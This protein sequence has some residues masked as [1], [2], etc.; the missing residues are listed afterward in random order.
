MRLEHF[1]VVGDHAEYR[2][3]G[4][5]S[6][7][8]M[9]QLV[10]SAI[11]LARERQVRKLLVVTTELTGFEPPNIVDR[12]FFIREWAAAADRS[13][14]VAMVA[15]REMIDP[16]KF[17]VTVAANNGMVADIFESEEAALAWLKS[18]K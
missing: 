10:G 8:E 9:A 16:Q 18:L 11:D 15:R 4:R 3:A 7:A 2:P 17:G 12:Y 5:V 6:Q 13:V 1:G 14:R